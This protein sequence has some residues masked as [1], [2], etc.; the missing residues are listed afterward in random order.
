MYKHNKHIVESAQMLMHGRR[1]FLLNDRKVFLILF[2]NFDFYIFLNRE[3]CIN[4][5]RK[6]T[7]KNDFNF[8]IM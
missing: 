8:L 4:I 3:I 7:F 5:R 6:E 1:T 2:Y